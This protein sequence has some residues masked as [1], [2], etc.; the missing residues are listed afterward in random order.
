MPEQGWEDMVRA[1]ELSPVLASVA[2]H[3]EQHNGEWKAF[4]DLEAPE[5]APMPGNFSEELD[6]FEQML[7]MRCLRVDRVT[8]TITN[9]VIGR[10]GERYVTPPVLDY[11]SIYAQSGPLTPVVFV[12]SPGADPAFDVFKLGESMGYKPG[13]KLKYMALGQGMG[14]KAQEFLETGAARGLW[15]MLQNCHLLPSWLKTLEKIL[16]RKPI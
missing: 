1:T 6:Q 9:Y 4:Y 15:V 7:V 14:P 8:V 12:L 16:K 5:N 11:K 13:A 10:M 3:M 2:E